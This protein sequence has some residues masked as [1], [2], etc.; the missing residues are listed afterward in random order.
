MNKVFCLIGKS[1]AGKSTIEKHL[2]KMNFKHTISD[3]TRP[4]RENEVDGKDYNFISKEEFERRIDADLYAEYCQYKDW[5][6]GTPKYSFDLDKHSYVC[7]INP[8][9]FRQLKKNLGEDKVVGIYICISDKTRLKRALDRERNPDCHEMCRRFL[10]DAE[11][12]QSIEAECKYKIQN[13][14]ALSCAR[15]IAILLKG[16][17]IYDEH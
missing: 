1:G 6:Y 11:D 17:L 13:Y 3:T 5:Y 10:A 15:T 8:R 7:T 9:G 4:P 2:S 16:E 14:D 12:F